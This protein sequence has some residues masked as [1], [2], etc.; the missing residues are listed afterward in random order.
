MYSDCVVAR[1]ILRMKETHCRSR[2]FLAKNLLYSFVTTLMLQI[3]GL[4]SKS[5]SVF[6]IAMSPKCLHFVMEMN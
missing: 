2:I 4:F 1:V 5:N 3:A 6:Q